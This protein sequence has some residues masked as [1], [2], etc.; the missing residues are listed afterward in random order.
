MMTPLPNSEHLQI[1][2]RL[3]VAIQNAL[4]YPARRWSMAA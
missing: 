3:Q 1:Q 4:G 2:H